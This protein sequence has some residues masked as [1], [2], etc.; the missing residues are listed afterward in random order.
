MPC[1]AGVRYLGI[2]VPAS[3]ASEVFDILALYKSDYYYYYYYYYLIANYPIRQHIGKV[4]ST[5]Y[6]Q[7]RRLRLIHSYVSGEL[8]IQLVTSLVMS[9]TDYCNSVLVGLPSSTMS[10]LQRVPNAA[11]WLILG[12]SRQ[13]HITPA[14]Q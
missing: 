1:S 7:L 5:C 10:P 3:I 4:A 11:A 2:L 6:Y 12:L 8:V 9:H 13:P 14:T